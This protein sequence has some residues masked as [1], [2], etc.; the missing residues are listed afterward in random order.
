MD[1]FALPI[2]FRDY[3]LF[4]IEDYLYS[5]QSKEKR[6]EL[7]NKIGTDRFA[8][9]SYEQDNYLPAG[10][11]EL[12]MFVEDKKVSNRLLNLSKR[13]NDAIQKEEINFKE[14]EE[15]TWET[16]TFLSGAER[17]YPAAINF[18]KTYQN[19]TLKTKEAFSAMPYS[20]NDFIRCKSFTEEY[21]VNVNILINVNVGVTV[22]LVALVVIAAAA[23]VVLALFAWVALHG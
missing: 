17:L 13:Y 2:D 5:I 6:R 4:A 19:L 8:I 11:F 1:N 15:I 22:T 16:Y 3:N 9:A 18:L 23:A 21:V 7:L 12:V 10:A 20:K 14:I